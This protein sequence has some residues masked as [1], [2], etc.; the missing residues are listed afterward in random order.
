MLRS[1]VIAPLLIDLI[2]GPDLAKLV[3]YATGML[4]NRAT[5]LTHP[6]RKRTKT[7]SGKTDKETPEP[8]YELE[9]LRRHAYVKHCHP[10][11]KFNPTSWDPLSTVL[12]FEK[13]F[14][15]T[16]A[17]A[18]ALL[19]DNPEGNLSKILTQQY[20]RN[21]TG[22]AADVFKLGNGGF[23]LVGLVPETFE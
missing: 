7:K 22:Y 8:G 12:V 23:V 10:W 3:L 21:L 2:P 20:L 5:E 6:P 16:A 14:A 15:K 11:L 19:R 1:S 18:L 4:G 17:H 9:D 13:S